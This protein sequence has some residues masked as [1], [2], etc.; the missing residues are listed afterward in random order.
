MT[1]EPKLSFSQTCFFPPRATLKVFLSYFVFPFK[2]KIKIS[3]D[4]KSFSKNQFFTKQIKKTSHAVEWER[5]WEYGVHKI[6]TS[7]GIIFKGSNLNSSWG[8]CGIWLVDQWLPLSTCLCMIG[9][10]L[11]I[12]SFDMFICDACLVIIVHWRCWHVDYIDWFSYLF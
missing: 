10:W 7:L 4:S 12:E 5:T 2:N 8:K 11:R 6:A 9:C 3:G 1:P